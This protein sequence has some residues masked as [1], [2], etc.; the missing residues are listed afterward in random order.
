MVATSNRARIER[1]LTE[2]G[3]A[4]DHPRLARLTA[5]DEATA[6][7]PTRCTVSGDE[8]LLA[9][10]ASAAWLALVDAAVRDGVVLELVSGFRSYDYQRDLIR[11]KLEAGRALDEVLQS[12][13]PPGY[14]EHHT[15]EAADIGSPGCDD[16][17]AAFADC[18]AFRWLADRAGRFGWTM[19]YPPGNDFGYV[20]EPWHWKW[21]PS[22]RTP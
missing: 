22:P 6:L 9:P 4:P 8:H 2:L 7:V 13:A 19:S 10:A 3:M 5:F 1:I 15:G 16:L 12:V 18:G 20:Y 14:S 11:R 21:H 17:T